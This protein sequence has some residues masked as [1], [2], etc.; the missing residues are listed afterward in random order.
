MVIEPFCVVSITLVVFWGV[1]TFEISTFVVPS[2]AIAGMAHRLRAMT[3]LNKPVKNLL[4]FFMTLPLFICLWF[5]LGN[6]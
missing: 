2:A 1:F 3:A 5:A 4:F 6:N